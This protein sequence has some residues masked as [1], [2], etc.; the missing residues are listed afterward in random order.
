VRILVTNDDGARAPGLAVLS[1]RLAADFPDTVVAVPMMD[2]GGCGTSIR[3]DAL[4]SANR[5]P[6]LLE[7]ASS[8]V[9][10]LLAPPALVVLAAGDGVF[11]PAPDMVV[12][13][14]NY[15]PNVGRAML[16]SGTVGAALTAATMGIRALAV[17]LDDL[18]STGGREDGEMHWETAVAVALPVIRWLARTAPGTALNVNVPNRQLRSIQGVR[19]ARPAPWGPTLRLDPEHGRLEERPG[20]HHHHHPPERDRAD[21]DVTLLAAGYV[22][23][24]SLGLLSEGTVDTCPAAHWLE[25]LLAR[26]VTVSARPVDDPRLSIVIP[27]RNRVGFLREC[28]ASILSGPAMRQV[29]VVDDA[30]DDGTGEWLRALADPR[31]EALPLPVNVGRAQAR[32]HGLGLVRTPFVMFM[33]DD[34]LLIAEAADGLVGLLDREPSAVAAIG[35]SVELDQQG[36]RHER[37]GPSRDR[38]C[39]IFP[40][41][42]A[43][44]CPSQGQVV[45]RT[46]VIR[47]AGAWSTDLKLCDD[48]ELW[49]RVAQAG[50]VAL[51]PVVAV[52]VRIHDGQTPWRNQEEMLCVGKQLSRDAARRWKAPLK[53]ARVHVAAWNRYRAPILE[54]KGHPLAAAASYLAALMVSPELRRSVI[55]GP[56]L[57][58]E[59][60]RLVRDVARRRPAGLGGR[61]GA[62]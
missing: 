11:G 16:H 46:D 26:R 39:T 2:C 38:V 49:L 35:R 5:A 41:V 17:S 22:T 8:R 52:E 37:L 3:A 47:G 33:D 48:Y 18:Y 60:Q 43:G 6:G 31:V 44:W 56:E 61:G 32:N 13:G 57:R 4:W 34:D 58:G 54:D 12:V 1:G 42:L 25:G 20:I 21:S 24:T 45:Y 29:I 50:P 14:V 27:T 51:S 62:G 28:L 30:S 55:I 15:G 19:A 7:S 53:A 59:L 40:E 23:I 9:H 36:Q 10:V